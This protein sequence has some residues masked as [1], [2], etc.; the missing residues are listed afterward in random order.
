MAEAQTTPPP[1]KI[2]SV[3][4]RVWKLMTKQERQKSGILFLGTIVNSFVE[5]LGLAAVVPVIG[6]VIEPELIRTNP[7][8]AQAFE[9]SSIIGIDT[10]RRFLMLTSVLLVAAFLFKAIFNLGLNLFQTRFSLG[11]GHRIS[12]LMWQYHFAQSLEKMRSQ[13]SGR[14]LAEI[15]GWPGILANTFIVGGMRLIN[16]VV[17]IALIG[18]G[19]LAY[20]P[21]VL[22]SVIT[23]LAIGATV[24]RKGTKNRLDAYSEVS[25]VLDPQTQTIINNAI[26]GFLEVITFRA[27]NSVLRGFLNKR[28]ILIRISSNSQIMN[29]APAKLYEVLAVTAVSASIFISLLLG[30]S[31]EQ[32]LNLLILMALSAYRVMPSMTRVNAQ[33]MAMRQYKHVLAVI[34]AALAELDKIKAQPLQQR[35]QLAQPNIRLHN[36]TIGYES[37]DAPVL[38]SFSAEFRAGAI[39]AIVGPSGSGKSTLVNTILGLHAPD[40]GEIQT[41]E[42]ESSWHKLGDSLSVS[43][44]LEHIGY[45]SQQPYLFNGTV[46]ENLTMMIPG[47]TLDEPAIEQLIERLELTDCLGD[48][49]LDFELLEGGNNLSGGQ[50][51]RLAILRA[52]RVHRPVLIL[53]EATSALDGVKRDAVFELLR[54]RANAGT[55]VLLIT[56]DMEL[57][58]QCDTVLDLGSMKKD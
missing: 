13:Q 3:F 7:Y 30:N 1:F 49:P 37:L 43:N 16:E 57:A 53:D 47:E 22:L 50:Q 41:A 9:W 51:Q 54:E 2:L 32:F 11:I 10:E 14:V 55:N 26:R 33:F 29:M 12:G 8:L 25:K 21:I 20:E 18:V 42:N 24:I 45:L 52:L 6:L 40:S 35:I 31:N 5:I 34:E 46:R 36:A 48:N 23:L 38:E 28:L 39:N 17:V 44:W 27:S 15:N 4:P 56:H 19:L 58:K